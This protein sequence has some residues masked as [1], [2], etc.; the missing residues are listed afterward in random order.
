MINKNITNVKVSTYHG[1]NLECVKFELNGKK[2]YARR[3]WDDNGVTTSCEYGRTLPNEY[4]DTIETLRGA[5]DGMNNTGV[6]CVFGKM[7]EDL[8]E[9]IKKA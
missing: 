6:S 8:Y 3:T 5:T 4:Y 9:E 1:S 7:P 2:Y